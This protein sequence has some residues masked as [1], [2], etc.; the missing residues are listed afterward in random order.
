ARTLCARI[1]W[2]VSVE[3]EAR[4][5]A[6]PSS[7]SLIE[8]SPVKQGLVSSACARDAAVRASAPA[9]TAQHM[10]WGAR[11][12]ME[13]PWKLLD[14]CFGGRFR[15]GP[16]GSSIELLSMITGFQA[17]CGG[18]SRR[19]PAPCPA[20]PRSREGRH[21]DPSHSDAAIRAGCVDLRAVVLD[22]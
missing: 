11:T 20:E 10:T 19:G 18:V 8:P 2:V 4:K 6:Q 15:K 3:P 7:T 21:V 14:L 12:R 22:G 1:S 13:P 17:R 5:A 16:G 9:K